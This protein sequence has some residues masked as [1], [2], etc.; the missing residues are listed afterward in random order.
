M[1]GSYYTYRFYDR[2]GTER[3]GGITTDLSRRE[4]EHQQTWPGGTI[5]KVGGPMTEAQARAWER[6]HGYA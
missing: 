5:R 2:N 3:H 1:A 6:Q 4:G